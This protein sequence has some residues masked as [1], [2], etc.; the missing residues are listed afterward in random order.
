MSD[1][2][3]KIYLLKWRNGAPYV[4]PAE[5]RMEFTLAEAMRI[6][7]F[8]NVDVIDSETGQVIWHGS[9]ATR[10]SIH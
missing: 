2:N 10:G 4:H 6:A 8:Q 3:T 9:E 5:H 1:P 7:E